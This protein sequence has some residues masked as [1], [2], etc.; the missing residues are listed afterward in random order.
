MYVYCYP[1]PS[2]SG[3]GSL[4]GAAALLTCKASDRLASHVILLQ[5]IRFPFHHLQ[6]DRLADYTYTRDSP[7]YPN[8]TRHFDFQPQVF[9]FIEYLIDSP[10]R[11]WPRYERPPLPSHPSSASRHNPPHH[12]DALNVSKPS[13]ALSPPSGRRDKALS[14]R[15]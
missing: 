4:L 8:I 11:S 14:G 15:S 9:S 3:R 13:D 1:N 2:V 6:H 12:D 10:I 5:S 7:S